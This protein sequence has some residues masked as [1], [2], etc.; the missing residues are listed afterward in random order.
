MAEFSHLDSSGNVRMVDVS[1]KEVSPRFA[2]AVAFLEMLPETAER[3]QRNDLK[4]G[5]VL[6]TARLAGIL[7]AKKTPELI[8]LCHGIQL[9]GV[10]LDLTFVAPTTLKITAEVRAADRTG[11]EMEALT[12]VAL[13]ALTCYDMCK[14]ID[15]SMTIREISLLEKQ[16]GASGHYLRPAAEVAGGKE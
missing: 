3:L 10:D 9:T 5:N 1:Q 12:A 7:A 4:K 11:V 6:A 14:A 15:R 8:P 16:G 2:S 13:A